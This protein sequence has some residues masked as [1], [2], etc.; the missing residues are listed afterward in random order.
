MTALG[1]SSVTAVDLAARQAAGSAALPKNAD[2]VAA[3]PASDEVWVTSPV[4]DKIT[5]LGVG[6]LAARATIASAGY[7]MRLRFTP[8]GASALAILGKASQLAI[9]DA[10]G[11]KQVATVQ[12]RV[13][14]SAMRGANFAQGYEN[15]TAPLGIALSPDGKWAFVTNGAVDAV[16]IISVPRR[17][18]VHVVFV[19]RE[20]DGVG[21]SALVRAPAE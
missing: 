12:L 16:S 1:A 21:Y 9:F 5:V 14:R 17:E 3:R 11:R 7:P 15:A 4:S 6:D 10:A 13:S 20:P 2:G 19:G 18:I 8:D